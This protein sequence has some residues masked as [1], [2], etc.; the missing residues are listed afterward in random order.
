MCLQLSKLKANSILSL[1]SQ[2]ILMCSTDQ[3]D[4]GAM[5]FL[6]RWN[7]VQPSVLKH[8]NHVRVPARTGIGNRRSHGMQ[9]QSLKHRYMS[10]YSAPCN[11]KR[12]KRSTS[13]DPKSKSIELRGEGGECRLSTDLPNT[14]SKS[15]KGCQKETGEEEYMFEGIGNRV[16][17]PSLLQ[18]TE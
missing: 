17:I 12:F 3:E 9:N 11:P 16:G 15:Q 5:P 6:R 7:A 1:S 13:R 2:F 8:R 10:A 14:R 18:C 4:Q